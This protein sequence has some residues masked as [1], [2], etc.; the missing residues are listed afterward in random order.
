MDTTIVRSNQPVTLVGGGKARAGDLELALRHAPTLV[1][2]D[3][4]AAM[5]LRAGHMPEA[6]L[7]DMDSL[8]EEIKAR[9]PPERLHSMADQESTDFDKALRSVAAPLVL[10]VGFL[11][12]RVDHQLANFNVLVRRPDRPCVLIGGRDVV[13][14][15]PPRIA[16]ALAPGRR[17]SLFPMAPVRGRSRGLHW[18]IDGLKMSPGGVIGTSNRV[19]EGHSGA[20]VITFDE[21]G[22]LLILPRAELGAVLDALRRDAARWP[23]ETVLPA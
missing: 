21:P 5:A 23:A 22:M 17:V 4:G 13:L 19:A 6:V 2:A 9:I 12:R 1:A 18:P 16:L 10:G 3:S 11:G 8:P 14:A 7:G 20:V 15:A